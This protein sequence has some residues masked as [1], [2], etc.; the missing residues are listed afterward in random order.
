M[1]DTI[2]Y[3]D[4]KQMITMAAKNI[5]LHC[6]ELSKMDAATGDGDH[7]TTIVR[8][9]DI[10]EKIIRE[11]QDKDLK[12]LL[13]DVGWGVMGVDGGATG[14][15]L[16]SFLM[17]LSTGMGDQKIIDP[18]TMAQMFKAGLAGVQKRSKAKVGD[19][20]LMDTL[21][22]AVETLSKAVEDNASIKDSLEAAAKAA[23]KGARSTKEFKARFGRAKN[24]GD[25]TLGC[26]DPGAT[27]MALIF[28]GFFEAMV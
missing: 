22:P 8:A 27:S 11:G 14:P 18:K 2:E 7:G 12:P 21:I 16:G 5:R 20:T 13:K 17:G 24:L 1:A 10:A 3:K 6:D 19:K 23:Q 26:Q 4:I 25:R 28:Q 9:M 15:L